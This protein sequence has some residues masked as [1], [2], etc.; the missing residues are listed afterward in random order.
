MPD[1]VRNHCSLTS[2]Y[3]RHRRHH[4][5]HMFRIRFPVG[6]HMEYAPQLQFAFYQFGK[7]APERY[8][9]YYGA[10]CA[11]GQGKRAAPCAMNC[12]ESFYAALQPHRDTS[13]AGCLSPLHAQKPGTHQRPVNALQCEEVLLGAIFSHC[14]QRRPHAKTNLKRHRRFTAKKRGEIQHIFG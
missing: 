10:L 5:K 6:R 14:H 3:N 4:F 13:R 8:G 12:Q 9:V 2:F 7:T 1:A 11:T